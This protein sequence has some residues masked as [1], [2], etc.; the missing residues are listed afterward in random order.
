MLIVN[1]ILLLWEGDYVL[2]HHVCVC[3]CVGFV[4]GFSILRFIPTQLREA[5]IG[6]KK[7]LTVSCATV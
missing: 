5:D 2:Q 7:I 6:Q 4:I 1:D 3:V